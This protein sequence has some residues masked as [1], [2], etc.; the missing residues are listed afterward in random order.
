MDLLF[1]MVTAI[2]MC[3]NFQIF[4]LKVWELNWPS[5]RQKPCIARHMPKLDLFMV[6]SIRIYILT[7]IFLSLAGKVIRP[8]PA[9][10]NIA[11]IMKLIGL[12]IYA[13][14]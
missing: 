9:L 13:N 3:S 14:S 6:S 1:D 10:I 2:P 12:E 5:N 8:S 4:A 7:Q 11:T